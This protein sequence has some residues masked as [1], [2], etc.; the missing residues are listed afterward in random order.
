MTED[1]EFNEYLERNVYEKIRLPH[2]SMISTR[3]A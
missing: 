3:S 2:Y 1:K